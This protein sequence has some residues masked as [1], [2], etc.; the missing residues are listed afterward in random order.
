MRILIPLHSKICSL[1]IVAL[2]FSQDLAI[3]YC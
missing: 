1:Y 2:C 3:G